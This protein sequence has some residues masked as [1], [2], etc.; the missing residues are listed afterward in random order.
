M[1]KR[2]ALNRGDILVLLLNGKKKTFRVLSSKDSMGKDADSSN[3]KEPLDL[4][5]SSELFKEIEKK[6]PEVFFKKIRWKSNS[7]RLLSVK[8]S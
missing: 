8:R 6:L 4:N 5:I 3:K 7:V 1:E 2:Y